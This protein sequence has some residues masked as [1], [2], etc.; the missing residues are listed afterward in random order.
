VVEEAVFVADYYAIGPGWG[1]GGKFRLLLGG[2]NMIVLLSVKY[3][4][5]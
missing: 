1:G 4:V 5:G 2:M 3:F